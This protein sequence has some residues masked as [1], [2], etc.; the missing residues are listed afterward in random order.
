LRCWRH[1]WAAGTDSHPG[2]FIEDK[3]AILPI[4][5]AIQSNLREHGRT[6]LLANLPPLMVKR[7][8][9]KRDDIPAATATDAKSTQVQSNVA[10]GTLP[11][12]MLS[13]KLQAAYRPC[14]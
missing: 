13:R 11:E 9:E 7:Q 1:R 4:D 5:A 10:G 3:N 12:I 2:D 6:I 8:A 14:K